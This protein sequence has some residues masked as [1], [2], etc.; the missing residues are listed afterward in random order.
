M[1]NQSEEGSSSND[2]LQDQVTPQ[3]TREGEVARPLHLSLS[4]FRKGSLTCLSQWQALPENPPIHGDGTSTQSLDLQ[5]YHHGWRWIE[6]GQL[7]QLSCLTRDI[8]LHLPQSYNETRHDL[9]E[10]DDMLLNNS[11][12]HGSEDA[13]VFTEEL[14]SNRPPQAPAVHLAQSIVYSTTWRVPVL[15]LDGWVSNSQ[16]GIGQSSDAS[17]VRGLTVDDVLN[18]KATA[19]QET[20]GRDQPS[21]S[22]EHDAGEELNYSANTIRPL[23]QHPPSD[24]SMDDDGDEVSDARAYFPPITLADHPVNGRPSMYLHPCQTAQIIG[25]MLQADADVTTLDETEHAQRY[26]QAFLTVCASAIEMRDGLS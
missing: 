13:T 23:L 24:H 16:D 20:N 3:T 6:H 18:M 25:E 8:I 11:L 17:A 15:W 7:S 19:H 4:A 21:E 5:R 1:P 9:T 10:D 22:E 2:N 26:L 12:E 14:Q